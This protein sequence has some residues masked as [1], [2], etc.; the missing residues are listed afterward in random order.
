MVTIA[1]NPE[2]AKYL[3]QQSVEVID[4]W[5][6]GPDVQLRITKHRSS[7]LGDYRPIN[8]GK[9]HLISVNGNLNKY[10][11]F[12]TLVHEI[13]HM[14]C[15]IAYRNRVKPHGKEWKDEF[16]RL[17]AEFN[18]HAIFPEILRLKI[19][20]YMKNPRASSSS[21]ISLSMALRE[22]DDRN[23][24]LVV[25][26]EIQ[27]N[28]AFTAQNGRTFI[29]GTRQRKRYKCREVKSGRLYLFNPIT[30]VIPA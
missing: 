6:S 15:F 23:E 25:L 13:A 12:L 1:K 10:A 2:I 30:E 16:K 11:F 21:D 5:L 29:K 3:P 14:N 18:L 8:R 24:H 17:M 20:D 9:Q 27:L 28:A 26:S 4:L 19:E 22:Y 7:K